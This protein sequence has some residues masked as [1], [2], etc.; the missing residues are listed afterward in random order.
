MM[1]LPAVVV[2]VREFVGGLGGG[3]RSVNHDYTEGAPRAVLA[4]F[5]KDG[6][7][8]PGDVMKWEMQAVCAA[9]SSIGQRQDT[10]R[11]RRP[12]CPELLKNRG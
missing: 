12:G 3:S 9:G 1:S 2:T 10:R 7:P 11:G 6:G 5:D 8:A 4:A